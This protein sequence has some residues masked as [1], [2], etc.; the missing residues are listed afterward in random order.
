MGD[1]VNMINDTTT[2]RVR[3]LTPEELKTRAALKAARPVTKRT[4][5]LVR[6][7]GKMRR[8]VAS[9]TTN[10]VLH[11]RLEGTGRTEELSLEACYDLAVK[12]RVVAELAAKKRNRSSKG[13]FA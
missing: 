5:A 9:I 10:G 11:L 7:G 6:D 3:V 2:I 13:D 12:Q 8:I 4:E 1:Y